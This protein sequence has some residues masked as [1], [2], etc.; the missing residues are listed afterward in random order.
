MAATPAIAVLEAA[1]IDFAL[2]EYEVPDH[3][4]GYGDAVVDA[5]G[6]DPGHVGKTLV[7][8]LDDIAT[9]AVVPVS[10]SLDLK[11]LARAGGAK[12][13]AMATH[14]EAERLSGS[15]VGGIAPLGHRTRLP[16]F[17]DGSLMDGDVVHVSGGRRGLEISLDPA[18]LVAACAATVARIAR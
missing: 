5:L 12:R 2:T 14:V 11:A 3:V 10:G 15:A 4:G 6:L 7:A 18:A 8:M 16:V 17:V 9:V 13:A 1:G